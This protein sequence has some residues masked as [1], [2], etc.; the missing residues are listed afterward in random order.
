MSEKERDAI[1]RDI[2]NAREG[3]SRDLDRLDERFGEMKKSAT[4]K[5]PFVA[6]GAAALGLAVAFIPRLI[7]RVFAKKN[8]P[9]PPAAKRSRKNTRQR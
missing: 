7:R 3:V 8:T 2:K 9:P 1:R 4:S 6:A 5:I